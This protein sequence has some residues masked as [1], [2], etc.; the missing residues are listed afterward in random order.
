[1][2]NEERK[3]LDKLSSMEFEEYKKELNNLLETYNFDNCS[4]DFDDEFRYQMARKYLKDFEND[5]TPFEE[6]LEKWFNSLSKEDQE[7]FLNEDWSEFDN[8]E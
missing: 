4:E 6:A 5:D 1:M 7:A 2:T 8:V 3:L